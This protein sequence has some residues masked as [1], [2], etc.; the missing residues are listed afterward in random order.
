[1]N[2]TDERRREQ[3]REDS[4]IV[5]FSKWVPNQVDKRVHLENIQCFDLSSGGIGVIL[6]RELKGG[7]VLKVEYPVSDSG[8]SVPVYAKVAWCNLV[9]E[10]YRAG[11]QFLH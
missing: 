4:R 11:L 10:T 9:G 1:M 6:S 3:R 7:E 5:S 2:R 8:I